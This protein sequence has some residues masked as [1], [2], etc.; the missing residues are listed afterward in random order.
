MGQFLT[1]TNADAFAAGDIPVLAPDDF[2]DAVSV[3]LTAEARLVALHAWDFPDERRL[4]AILA[5]EGL[6]HLLATSCPVGDEYP[7]FTPEC[8]AAHLF[9]REIYEDFGITPLGHPWLKPLRRAAPGR[10]IGDIDFFKVQGAQLHE[11]GVGPVHAGVI[12]PGHFRFACDG[13]KVLHLEISLGY[14]HRGLMRKFMAA[15]AFTRGKIVETVAGDS[16]IA[17]SLAYARAVEGLRGMRVSETVDAWRAMALELERLAN[18]VG[19]LGALS[20][21]AGFLPSASYCGRL[22]GDILNTTALLCGNRFGRNFITPGGL[23]VTP[24]NGMTA[25]LRDRVAKSLRECSGA[26]ELLLD[27]PS[28]LARFDEIGKISADTARE[29]GMVGVAARAAGLDIDVRYDFPVCGLYAASG[30]APETDKTGDVCARARVRWAECRQSFALLDKWLELLDGLGTK[31]EG[32]A[33]GLRPE[34]GVVSLT[35]GWRG[36]VCH[37]AF[38]DARGELSGYRI[39]DPSFHNWQ[40]LAMALRDE[41]ISNFPLCNKSFNLSYCGVDL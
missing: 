25:T 31:D 39:V 23:V 37:I 7:A 34:M 14:Q 32:G 8:P 15:D 40:G 6:Q 4:V 11:V 13:E 20:G 10:K 19:D 35:E 22:R 36:E 5:D 16:S 41:E 17:H 26:V 12:E 28:V 18:H 29:L 30:F 21:D 1:I 24:E 38:T 2:R 33:A 3:M 27:T 9:E